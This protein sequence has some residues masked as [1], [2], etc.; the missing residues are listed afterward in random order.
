MKQCSICAWSKYCTQDYYTVGFPHT[1]KTTTDNLQLLLHIK[2]TNM[3]NHFFLA[4]IFGKLVHDSSSL[5]KRETSICLN[6]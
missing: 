4:R 5:L 1:F 3:Y 2:L 6:S